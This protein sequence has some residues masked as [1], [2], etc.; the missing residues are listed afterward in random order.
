LLP[1]GSGGFVLDGYGG[2]FPFSLTGQ[3]APRRPANLPYWRGWD[4]ARDL[5][6][7]HDGTGGLVLDGLGGEHRVGNPSRVPVGIL[8]SW[9]FPIARGMAINSSD[10]GAFVL[11]GYGGLHGVSLARGVPELSV[12]PLMTGLANP[13]DVA[14]TNDGWLLYTE[15]ANGISAAH[16]DGSNR[17]LLLMPSDVQLGSEGGVLGLAL[18][19]A[20]ASN[21]R[22]YVCYSSNAPAGDANDNRLVRFQVNST[23]SV[24]TNATPVVTGLPY[25]SGRHSGCRPRFGPDGRLYVGTGDAAVGT[26]PQSKTSL[27]GKVL[28]VDTSGNGVPGNPGVDNPASGWD[29]R[30]FNWGHRNVQGIAFRPSDGLGLSVEHGTD[31]DDEVNRI[32]GGANYGWDPVPGYDESRPMTDYQK[33]PGATGPLWASGYP[34]IAPSGATFLSGAKWRN[35]NGW[36]AVAV[37]KGEQLRVFSITSDGRLTGSTVRLQNGVRLRSAVQGPDG[38]LYVTTD[39]RPGGDQIWKITPH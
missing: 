1:D 14:F 9:S 22:V 13:W 20:F 2:V 31:R 25:S 19:P 34:T 7:L 4:I 39:S 18:D 28:R 5:A 38:D 23:Y 30:I 17:R 16:A 35:W 24:L 8:P 11:D 3:P 12:Q 32:L 10:T 6:L 37:L 29:P 26:N 27:G 33:F 36:L 15:R 21:R